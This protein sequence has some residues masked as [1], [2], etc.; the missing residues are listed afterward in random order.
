MIYHLLM[1]KV[2]FAACKMDVK[3][4]SSLRYVQCTILHCTMLGKPC[5]VVKYNWVQY[6][7]KKKGSVSQVVVGNIVNGYSVQS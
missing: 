1:S 6:H 2:Y 4:R 5:A 7:F 3:T